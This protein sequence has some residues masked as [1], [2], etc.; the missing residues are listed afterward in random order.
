MSE[1]ITK[2]VA[3]NKGSFND[4]LPLTPELIQFCKEYNIDLESL[5]V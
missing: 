2:K 4:Y 5:N 1:I 3:H